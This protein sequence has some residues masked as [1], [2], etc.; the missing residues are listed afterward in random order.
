MLKKLNSEQG[1][2][3]TELLIVVAI[4][5]ILVAVVLPNFVG[6]LGTSKTSAGA[7]ELRI[8]QTAVDAKLANTQA[9]TT[10]A[11]TTA[12]SDMTTTAGGFSLSPTYMRSTATHGTYTVD[13]TGQV[14][15]ASYP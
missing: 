13:T 14:A 3:L 6:L 12:T 15:Q 7:A 9:S 8:V 1:F 5:G 11:I 2:T 10:T 4:L